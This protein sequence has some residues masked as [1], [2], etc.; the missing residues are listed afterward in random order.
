M[1]GVLAVGEEPFRSAPPLDDRAHLA[2][3][4]P[5]TSTVRACVH[6]LKLTSYAYAIAGFATRKRRVRTCGPLA[7]IPS[8]ATSAMP[9]QFGAI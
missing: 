1:H 4:M 9:A 5:L 8:P 6:V 2:S 3:E 7:R